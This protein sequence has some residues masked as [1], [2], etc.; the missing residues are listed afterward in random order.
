[1]TTWLNLKITKLNK[2]SKTSTWARDIAQQQYVLSI[3]EALGSIPS[4]KKK[5]KLF[6]AFLLN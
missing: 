1:M 6:I 4:T 5:K 2:G 3:C